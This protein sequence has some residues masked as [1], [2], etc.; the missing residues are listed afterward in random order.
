MNEPA[1]TRQ[2]NAIMAI[3]CALG[4]SS[5]ELEGYS[6]AVLRVPL[7]E[8]SKLQAADLI[9]RLQELAVKPAAAA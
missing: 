2:M 1:T 4:F 9:G 6:I 7:D 5:E 8:L 3:A